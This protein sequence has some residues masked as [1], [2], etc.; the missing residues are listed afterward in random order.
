MRLRWA[1]YRLGLWEF[2]RT[3]TANMSTYALQETYDAGR[4]RAHRLTLRRFEPW[5][6]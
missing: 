4:E 2:K 1:A 6:T 3:V 5:K